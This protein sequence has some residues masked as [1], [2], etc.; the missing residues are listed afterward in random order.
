M[1]YIY[2]LPLHSSSQE[3][4]SPILVGLATYDKVLHFYNL[5]PSLAQP[6]MMVVTDTADMFVPMVDGFLVNVKEARGVMERS[7]HTLSLSLSL[8]LKLSPLPQSPLPAAGDVFWCQTIRSHPG[9]SCQSW[10]GG[11]QGSWPKR[12]AV[13][14]PY[15]S[16]VGPGSGTAQEQTGFQ[17]VGN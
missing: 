10:S 9:T 4:G 6:G 11:A 14:I 17:T 13:S 15:R 7:A 8:S 5:K 16:P 2:P 3:E 12:S 1:N